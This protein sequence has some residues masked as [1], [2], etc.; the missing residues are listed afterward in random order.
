[1]NTIIFDLDGTLLPLDMDNFADK[2]FEESG[3]Y[4]SDLMDGK[5]FVKHLL[6]TA[7]TMVENIEPRTNE[8]VF[9]EA[10]ENGIDG[11]ITVYQDRF[12]D[13]FDTAFL[14]TK[15]C[16]FKT[17]IIKKA[18]QTLKEK[19]YNLVIAT[20]PVFP[21]KAIIHRIHWADL[22]P[23]DFSYISCYEKNHYCKPQIQF[24]EEVLSDIGKKAAECLMVGNDVQEDLIAGNLGIK[25][26]LI[27]DYLLHRTNEVIKTDSG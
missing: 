19:D 16:T 2:Y 20:N 6:S 25:T 27:E 14:K 26:F 22:D 5:K 4:F 10:F 1:M 7:Q 24:F 15:D 18:I 13:F 17:P 9:M 23:S 21:L 11:D 3:A 8:E 12:L